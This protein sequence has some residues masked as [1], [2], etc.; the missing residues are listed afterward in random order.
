[1][2]ISY[3][4]IM[5]MWHCVSLL[6]SKNWNQKLIQPFVPEQQ[7]PPVLYLY[8]ICICTIG[9]I[10]LC[11]HVEY[12]NWRPSKEHYYD[13]SEYWVELRRLEETCCHSNPSEKPLANA[14]WKTLKRVKKYFYKQCT[15]YNFLLVHSPCVLV[16]RG[17]GM[18]ANYLHTYLKESWDNKMDQITLKY[19]DLCYWILS[20]KKT[21]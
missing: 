1:M 15:V 5:G 4:R 7:S 14:E 9:L 2:S 19:L 3:I 12:N 20:I 18:F 17:S 13:W 8:C 11:M 6:V 21:D 16:C 10:S